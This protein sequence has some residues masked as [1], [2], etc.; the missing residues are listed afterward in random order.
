MEEVDKNKTIIKNGGE[1]RVV[2]VNNK[3]KWKNKK[4]LQGLAFVGSVVLVAVVTVVVLKLTRPVL[5]ENFFVSDDTKSTITIE[6]DT[7]GDSTSAV[8]RTRVVYDYDGENVVG[9]KTYFEFADN[10][11]ARRNEVAIREQPQFERTMVDGNFVIAISKEEQY[12]GLTKTDIEQQLQ[13]IEI[14][15]HSKN[16]VT[17]VDP[18]IV[19][20]DEEPEVEDIEGEQPEAE[21]FEDA[22]PRPED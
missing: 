11:T 9:M 3:K 19:V 12:K 6:P 2:A 7:D 13:A 10:E 5:D 20:E 17:D 1:G 4:L 8:I 22:E 21:E 15:M 18:N 14:Y 16:I